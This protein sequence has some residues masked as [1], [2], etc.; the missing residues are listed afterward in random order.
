MGI[1]AAVCGVLQEAGHRPCGRMGR[2]YGSSKDALT[3]HLQ[4]QRHWQVCHRPSRQARIRFPVQLQSGSHHGVDCCTCCIAVTNCSISS[5]RAAHEQRICLLQVAGETLQPPKPLPWYANK[6]AWHM[7]FS[8]GQLRKLPILAEIHE[9]LK[10]ENEAGSITRQEAVSMVP[11]LFL[12]VESHH[13][14]SLHALNLSLTFACR[15]P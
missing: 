15:V 9:L 1:A 2:I 4:N 10:R 6:L 13:R 8:R 12:G 7:S 5:V 3:N 11:P 14:V